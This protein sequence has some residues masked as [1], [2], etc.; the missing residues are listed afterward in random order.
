MQKAVITQSPPMITHGGAFNEAT[1]EK[2]A[3]A[4]FILSPYYKNIKEEC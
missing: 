3:E 1:Y 2:G 4:I